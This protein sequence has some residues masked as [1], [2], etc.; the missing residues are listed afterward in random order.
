MSTMATS[1]LITVRLTDWSCTVSVTCPKHQATLAQD[2]V[3]SLMDEVA[4]AVNRFRDDS[5]ITQIN[6]AAGRYTAVA[7]LTVELVDVALHAADE[8]D[9][10]VDP[11]LGAD[12]VALGYDDDIDVIRTRSARRAAT[13]R[14]RPWSWRDIKVDRA[15]H[16]VGVPD[17]MHIDLGATTK[18]W[19]VDEAARRLRTDGITQALVGIGGDLAVTGVPSRQAD[20][21]WQVDVAEVEGGTAQR[22]GVRFG[23][24]ATSSTIG[25]RWAG[26]DGSAR[27]H[28]LDPGTG[29]PVRGPWRTASVWAPQ[30]LA[31]NMASTWLLV[32]PEAATTA[33]VE[34][35]LAA[36]LVANDGSTQMIGAWPTPQQ[37]VQ[38]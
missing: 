8:T 13:A 36:R 20:D 3:G 23:A 18:A 6:R 33:V 4:R 16:R 32:A 34:K 24:I 15:L 26:A 35:G 19:T 14:M 27:H 30:C 5:D 1:N 38:S 11:S 10:A 29:L 37:E 17:G 2:V 12:L 9:G 28:L 22:I 7:P 25:R 21:A 31:A